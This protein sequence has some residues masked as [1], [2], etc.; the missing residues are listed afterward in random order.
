MVCLQGGNISEAELTPSS[1]R[2]T[3][4][5]D[6]CREQMYTFAETIESRAMLK[7]ATDT[8]QYRKLFDAALE[9]SAEGV[10]QLYGCAFKQA[11]HEEPEI[12]GDFTQALIQAGK[13]WTGS[14]VFSLLDASEVAK[15]LVQQKRPQQTPVC[16]L[17][18]RI[19][20]FPFA[21][22]P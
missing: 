22:E 17:G 7:S 14:G 15:K 9:R 6:S 20:H 18:R 13:K 12:G 4:I 2:T 21:V 10:C 16:N 5:L 8:T 3:V 1:S 11:A 19:N